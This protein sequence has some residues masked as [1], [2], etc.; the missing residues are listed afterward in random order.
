MVFYGRC[1]VIHVFVVGGSFRT[2]AAPVPPS[3]N[4][5]AYLFTVDRINRTRNVASTCATL[6][7]R[8]ADSAGGGVRMDEDTGGVLAVLQQGSPPRQRLGRSRE[9]RGLKAR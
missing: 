2:S 8:R 7:F 5:C 1:R 6:T 3:R 4:L 9:A